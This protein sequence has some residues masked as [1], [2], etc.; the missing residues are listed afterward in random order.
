MRGGLP[1]WGLG[2]GLTTPHRKKLDCYGML[3][4]A[5]ELFGRKTPR[6]RTRRRWEDIGIGKIGGKAWTAFI[7]LRVWTATWF[8]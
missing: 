5:F 7:W 1:A 8:L 4:M 2:E 6:G 3:H